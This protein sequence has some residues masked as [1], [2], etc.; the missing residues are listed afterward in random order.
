MILPHMKKIAIIL[1]LFV[2]LLVIIGIKY[3]EEVHDK[4]KPNETETTYDAKLQIGNLLLICNIA[5]GLGDVNWTINIAKELKR[6]TTAQITYLFENKGVSEAATTAAEAHLRQR[7]EFT[8]G[9]QIISSVDEL[10]PGEGNVYLRNDIYSPVIG[11]NTVEELL[12]NKYDFVIYFHPTLT[13][14]FQDLSQEN[15]KFLMIDEYGAGGPNESKIFF[16]NYKEI[17]KGM[18][19]DSEGHINLN[20]SAKG[21][22]NN[23]SEEK[24]RNFRVDYMENLE[25]LLDGPYYFNYYYVGSTARQPTRSEIIEYISSYIKSYKFKN[26]IEKVNITLLM[27]MKHISVNGE[28]ARVKDDV[29]AYMTLFDVTVK[30]IFYERL[31]PEEFEYLLLNSEDI[32]GCTGDMSITQ[33]LSSKRMIIY[34]IS[35][36]RKRAFYE[37]LN[38]EWKKMVEEEGSKFIKSEINKDYYNNLPS[39]EDSLNYVIQP[40]IKVD[41][42]KDLYMKFLERLENDSFQKWFKEELKNK[43]GETREEQV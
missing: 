15:K 40:I 17:Y 37:E 38:A 42:I 24:K 29:F 39:F 6:I 13:W 26:N 12:E 22:Y 14:E 23:L 19:S 11:T 8:K 2:C 25:K 4:R 7:S 18:I 21:F 43:L 16:K 28:E 35:G 10:E 9:I 31:S 36:L 27:N 41:G 30:I 1:V 3:K 20:V 33:V 5:G 32:A 34:E